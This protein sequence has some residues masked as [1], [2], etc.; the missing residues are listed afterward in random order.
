MLDLSLRGREYT[1]T[2]N[3]IE[4]MIVPCATKLTLMGGKED[5]IPEDCESDKQ[6]TID[7]L[8]SFNIVT[9]YN[10]GLFN[11]GDYEEERISWNSYVMQ[12]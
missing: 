12:S 1:G 7:W 11:Q 4:V 8:E 10:Q 2:F 5:R 3:A 6:V 9:Y